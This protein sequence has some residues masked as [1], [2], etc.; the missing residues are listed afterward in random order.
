[1]VSYRSARSSFNNDE[2]DPFSASSPQ[3]VKQTSAKKKLEAR[4]KAVAST[5]QW[6]A[7]SCFFVFVLITSGGCLVLLL[8]H[9]PGSNTDDDAS[10]TGVKGILSRS[11]KG[12]YKA[13][14]PAAF[15]APEDTDMYQEVGEMKEIL[16]QKYREHF[17]ITEENEASTEVEFLT[18][19]S[20][21]V[22]KSQ[23]TPSSSGSDGNFNGKAE[24]HIVFS[25]DCSPYQDWQSLLLFHAANAVGQRG[26]ITRIASGCNH[27]RQE[28]LT[29]LYKKLWGDSYDAHFTPDFKKTADGKSYD[30]YNKPY[31]MR[32][33]IQNY[34]RH[35]ASKDNVV[36]ALIDPDFIF[37][38]PIT[39]KLAG[40][41]NNIFY[42]EKTPSLVPEY[43]SEGVAVAQLY[44][45]GAPWVNSKRDFN[46]TKICPPSSP[47]LNTTKEF[48][49]EHYSVGP[50][51]ILHIRDLNRLTNAWCDFVPKVY[52]DY[53]E[54]LAEMYAYS[55]AAAHVNLPHITMQSHMVSNIA[56]SDEGWKWIDALG[57]DVCEEPIDNEF[58]KG[59][60]L[61]TFLHYCQFFRVGEIG[62]QKRRLHNMF[63][64]EHPL[65]MELPKDLGKTNY[66]NRDGERITLSGRDSRRGAFMLCTIHRAINAAAVDYK[67]KMCNDVDN[68]NYEKI[69]NLAG[70]TKEALRA[71]GF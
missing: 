27:N 6:T 19:S 59:K 63:T 68:V 42:N 7:I 69:H 41:P 60:P 10:S 33:F 71:L 58:Y 49:E 29:I 5:T 18:S 16:D 67:K 21:D 50:P 70:N 24:L 28:E 65:M 39:L 25:T 13:V 56:M 31:G 52:E 17:G 1:M 8:L 12:V 3:P 62:F 55:M 61:P 37:L 15:R 47:C 34:K 20:A 57:D 38:R 40:E 2:E 26:H 4:K 48:G 44:G 35:D 30:F 32:D 9:G 51:Y 36:I 54:L 11:A 46:K 53:P 43:I 14:V 45:L 64:C 22:S 66:K 23:S